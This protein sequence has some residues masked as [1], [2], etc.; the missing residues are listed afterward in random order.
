MSELRTKSKLF[1]Y[2]P[3]FGAIFGMAFVMFGLVFMNGLEGL[4]R[5]KAKSSTSFDLSQL[6]KKKRPKPKVTRKKKIKRTK[7]RVAPPNLA[8][9]MG[10]SSFG[11]GAFEFLAEGAEGLLGNTSNVI[12]TE[13]TVDEVPK[14]SYRPPLKYPDYARKR[15]INGQVTL[16]L[17]VSATGAVEVVKLLASAPEGLFDQ[18]AIDSV[19]QW[20][21]DP[22][23]YKGS[24]VKVWVKQKISFNLN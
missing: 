9:A 19:M 10:G 4:K 24:P 22:A 20:Q 21:F 2:L 7:P 18:V 6:Q 23:M 15:G 16:N 1:K 14:A 11:L 5:N 12:M 8:G 13:D 17:L 3:P